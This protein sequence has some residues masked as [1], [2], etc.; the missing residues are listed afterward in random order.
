M[1]VLRAQRYSSPPRR[2]A[3]PFGHQSTGGARMYRRALIGCLAVIGGL[4]HFTAGAAAPPKPEGKPRPKQVSEIYVIMKARL[5][6]VDEAFHNK[7]AKAKWR[8]KA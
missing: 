7:V 6:E 2:R 4:L 3:T 5:Y 1:A 8:S